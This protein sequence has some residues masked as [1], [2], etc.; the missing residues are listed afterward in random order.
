MSLAT[1]AHAQ[2][3]AC[4][5]APDVFDQ[6]TIDA[7]KAD[8][9]TSL[10]ASSALSAKIDAMT[11][12]QKKKNGDALAETKGPWLVVLYTD[13]IIAVCNGPTGGGAVPPP[14]VSSAIIAEILWH[15]LY[16]MSEGDTGLSGGGVGGTSSDDVWDCNHIGL[17]FQSAKNLCARAVAAAA[18]GKVALCKALKRAAIGACAKLSTPTR[19]GQARDCIVNGH[20]RS[21]PNSSGP[22]GWAYPTPLGS[23]CACACNCGN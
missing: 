18:A 22:P 17:Q 4:A 6:S 11:I 16:H 2:C 5:P 7:A 19:A 21:P 23:N 20:P 9:K 3:S 13:H 15:E 10:N 14:E 8:L 1:P 12:K